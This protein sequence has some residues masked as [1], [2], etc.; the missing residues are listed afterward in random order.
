MVGK[1]TT[2]TYVN[3]DID[4]CGLYT[5]YVDIKSEKSNIDESFK[6]YNFA[7]LKT[8]PMGIKNE[9]YYLTTHFEHYGSNVDGGLDV[10][11]KS[12][13]YGVRAGFGWTNVYDPSDRTNNIYKD[14]DKTFH[15][16]LRE[17]DLH[18]MATFGFSV[19][20]ETGG[21]KYL[22]KTEFALQSWSQAI[23]FITKNTKGL[24]ERI[25]IWNEP[26]I[27]D[28]NGGVGYTGAVDSYYGV[29]E[30]PEVYAEAAKAAMIGAKKGNP[31]VKVGVMSIVNLGSGGK[32][33]DKTYNFFK[34]AMMCLTF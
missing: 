1:K 32:V 22:P 16:K 21:W 17:N 7:I 28:F 14:A 30:P 15:S 9:N 3:V 29:K 11:A 19:T 26:N 2:T 5:L 10:I 12:N 24:V 34:T 8:D 20:A 6:R 18:L 23:E 31:D 25:E 33:I 27:L 4:R 13:T